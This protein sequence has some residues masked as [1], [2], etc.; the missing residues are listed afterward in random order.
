MI[1]KLVLLVM[2]MMLTASALA[3]S[4]GFYLP[5]DQVDDFTLT[6]TNDEEFVL[7]EQLGKIVV[8]DLWAEWCPNCVNYS[9]P[10]LAE[11]HEKYPDD[12]VVVAVNCGDPAQDV[13][14]YAA[15]MG[16]EF[17]VA[18]DEYLD[19]MY[20]Y[21]PVSGIPFTA[22]IDQEGKLYTASLG[23]GE[24]LTEYYLQIIDEMLAAAE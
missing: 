5:G 12:V 8:L 11:I 6:L 17:N 15:E 23:G 10:A 16:Y 7:S 13:K 4:V 1:R 20:N 18:I 22:F 2:A 24:G 9:L 21:F 19:I 3:G 14:D